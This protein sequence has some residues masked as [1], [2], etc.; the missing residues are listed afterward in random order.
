MRTLLAVALLTVPRPTPDPPEIARLDD[1]I[2]LRFL[3]RTS[4]GMNRI[5]PQRHHGVQSFRPENPTEQA[6]ID[7]LCANRYQVALFLVGRGVLDP[8]PQ[9][10]RNTLQGPAY[11][12]EVSGDLPPRDTLLAEGRAALQ[13]TEPYNLRR[14]E[15]TVSL[16]PLRASNA[17]CIQCHTSAKI[18]DT[19]GVAVYAYKQT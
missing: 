3:N 18:G 15:W 1:C 6:I 5:L 4:F 13:K 14:G 10:S 8:F 11:I 9:L 17:G 2:Q 16:R 7:Q 19:L 12:T